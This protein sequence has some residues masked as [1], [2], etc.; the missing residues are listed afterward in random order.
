MKRVVNYWVGA[1]ALCCVACQS[2]PDYQAT[3]TFEATEVLVSAEGNGKLMRLEVEEGDV[4]EG[5]REIGVIDTVQLYLKKLQL[6]ATRKSVDNQ[7]PDLSKQIAALQQQ[8]SK[9]IRERDRVKNLLQADAANRKQLDDWEAEIALLERQ[10]EAQ[11][12]S[13]GNNVSSLTEQSSSVGIQV[14]QVE[15]QL[16][17][18][19]IMSPI[20]GTVLAKYAE[21]GELT[22]VGRPLF[23]VAD[24]GNVYLRAYVT[25]TQL[26]RLKV[27]QQVTVFADYGTDT[28]KSYPG[29]VTWISS[30]SEFTPKTILTEDERANLV[31][32]VK[33][34]VKND[35]YIK[36]GMYGGVQF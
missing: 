34:A 24:L 25:S 12:S 27:G 32:A 13:L 4:L 22:A 10:I 6:L 8:L 3:G 7:R 16:A 29:T 31:Y 33:I 2:Q 28:R 30:T 20:T 21:Q 11:R 35:G 15:D 1:M 26:S 36:I 23:K 9:A 19:H 17:K 5:G 18:C 14:A